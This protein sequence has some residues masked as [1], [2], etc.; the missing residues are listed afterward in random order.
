MVFGETDNMLDYLGSDVRLLEFQIVCS[1]QHACPAF[2]NL[3]C[4]GGWNSSCLVTWTHVTPQ[5][6]LTPTPYECSRVPKVVLPKSRRHH[7]LWTRG[8]GLNQFGA[9]LSFLS[10]LSH[11]GL[12]LHSDEVGTASK[13]DALASCGVRS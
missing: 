5:V 11:L 12:F 1:R 4:M 13:V 6:I 10:S 9:L 3:P 8:T 7:Q 2:F